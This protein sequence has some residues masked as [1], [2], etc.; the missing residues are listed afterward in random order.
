MTASKTVW[1]LGAGQ[2]G[3]ML[4]HAAIPLNI[5][6]NPV[7]LDA[8]QIP[9]IGSD[10]IVTPEIEHWPDS[11]V[12]RTLASH[13][14]FINAPVFARLA[15]RL[16]QKQLIDSLGLA[17][18]P[19]REVTA[20][21]TS[22]ALHGDLGE[23]VLLKRRQG[24]YDGRGQYWLNQDNPEPV[25]GEWSG[26]AIAEAAIAFDEEVSL[27]GMRD[28]QG[29]ACYYPLT[30]NLHRDGILT[31]SIAPLR[32]LAELQKQAEAMLGALMDSLDYVG[33]MAMECFRVGDQLLINE[34][35]PRVHNSGHWTQAGTT[36]SQFE[37]HIRA[38]CD[39]PLVTPTLKGM[40]VM[41]NLLG[42]DYD[43]RWLSLPNA[44]LFWYG[45]DVRPGRKLGH[46]NL[47]AVTAENLSRVANLMPD[48]YEP[49]FTWVEKNCFTL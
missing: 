45:K 32:R 24:G 27:V 37:S 23:R 42:V 15:D 38:I 16:P 8:E 19:W 29:N 26:A 46:L 18:A 39:L 40:T 25:P 5:K 41:I 4:Q 44:E 21:I 17:T 31:A 30:L 20:E 7:A 13:K 33:V 35:A 9:D 48:S 36:V 10:H 1:V 22:E 3:T 2:L 12:T 49:V 34:L 43:Q 28:N 14:N 47:S 11:P 6:V